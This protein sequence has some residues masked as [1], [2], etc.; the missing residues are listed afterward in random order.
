MDI[1]EINKIT[2][3]KKAGS[4]RQH[5]YDFSNITK[6]DAV[7]NMLWACKKCYGLRNTVKIVHSLDFKNFKF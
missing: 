5:L 3:D 2:T 4:A 1:V 7:I 6:E